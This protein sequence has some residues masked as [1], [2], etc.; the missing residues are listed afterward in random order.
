M[1][2]GMLLSKESEEEANKKHRSSSEGLSRKEHVSLHPEHSRVVKRRNSDSLIG[3]LTHS[4]SKTV[5]RVGSHMWAN[6][7]AVPDSCTQKTTLR[8]IS[9]ASM[10]VGGAKGVVDFN[11]V[12]FGYLEEC[13][14][15]TLDKVKEGLGVVEHQLTL[16]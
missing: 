7:I 9:V 6:Y 2:G 1:K 13:L 15:S 4:A 8:A 14:I 5:R 16:P 3:I 12:K 10:A 11:P